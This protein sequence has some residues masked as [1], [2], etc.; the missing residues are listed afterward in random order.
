MAGESR[1]DD[2][3]VG[4]GV[5][6]ADFDGLGIGAV[7]G[8]A[9]PCLAIGDIGLA[10]T[11][12]EETGAIDAEEIDAGREAVRTWF[13]SASDWG[14]LPAKIALAA[15]L[16]GID[17]AAIIRV[18]RAATTQTLASLGHSGDFADTARALVVTAE[19]E[20][21]SAELRFLDAAERMLAA[22]VTAQPLSSDVPRRGRPAKA[23]AS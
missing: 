4:A 10:G 15:T 20:G 22:G 19:L 13:E 8:V 16:P 14:D 2:A 23:A 21:A 3:E 18:Q 7:G 1:R 5:A 6:D 11:D 17:T 12:V 9:E